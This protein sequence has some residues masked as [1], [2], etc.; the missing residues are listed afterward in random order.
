M[1]IRVYIDCECGCLI[2]LIQ[3]QEPSPFFANNDK[4]SGTMYTPVVDSASNRNEYQEH[5]MGVKAAGA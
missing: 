2:Q 3:D 4:T 1:C 5:F